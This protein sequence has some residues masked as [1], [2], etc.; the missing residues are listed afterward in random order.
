MP[1]GAP[2]FPPYARPPPP[3]NLQQPSQSG[4]KAEQ[5]QKPTPPP[6]KAASNDVKPTDKKDE[7]STD[8]VAEHLSKLNVAGAANLPSDAAKGKS[9]ANGVTNKTHHN[10]PAIPR[11]AAAAAAAANGQERQ[12]SG[13]RTV[14]GSGGRQR[15]P[16]SSVFDNPGGRRTNGPVEVPDTDFDFDASN[17]K[18]SK[19]PKTNEEEADEGEEGEEDSN[20]LS[21]IP[22]PSETKSF[23]DKSSFFD[24][25]SNEVT[26]RQEGQQN[27]QGGEEQQ[28][29]FGGRGGGRGGRGGG[30]GRAERLAEERRNMATF[31]EVGSFGGGGPRGRGRG[32]G[33][34]GR[35]RGGRGRGDGFR[36]GRGGQAATSAF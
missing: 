34:G 15:G 25:I 30:R 32:R 5:V 23:Y 26:E 2:G 20:V 31:G 33:R 17:A 35:G 16:Q 11:A 3:Q 10:L 6:T 22:P 8:A 7:S 36:G 14:P 9:D 21:S 27:R 28:G 4:P 29:Q 18:F 1:Y 13:G 12:S 24:S 19:Q